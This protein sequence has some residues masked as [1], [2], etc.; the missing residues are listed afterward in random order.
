MRIDLL[1]KKS[2]L[3]LSLLFCINFLPNYANAQLNITDNRTA[4][5]LVEK[6][7][8]TGVITLNASLNC[9]T[10]ANGF[11]DGTSNLGLDSGIVLSSGAVKTNGFNTGVDGS[12]ALSPSTSYGSAG[13]AMLTTLINSNTG[14]SITTHDACVLQFDFVP[15]GDTVKFDYVF[16]SEE[17]PTY[18][19]SINDVF[20]FF[21]SGPGIIGTRNIATVPG[22]TN[23]MVGIS[24]INNG[25]GSAVGNPCMQNTF[26]NGPYTQYYVNN[27]NGTTVTYNG[28]TQVLQAIS[29][30]SPCDTYHLK[31]AIADASDNILDSGV[32]IKA[33]SL[34]S[35]GLTASATGMNTTISD[36]ATIVRGCPSAKVTVKRQSAAPT[37]LN[38]PYILGGTAVNG[39]DYALLSGTVTIL[40][41]E[42]EGIIEIQ[43]LPLPTPV[44]NKEVIVYIT[45]PYACGSGAPNIL[46]SAVIVIQDSIRLELSITNTV[47]CLGQSLTEAVTY[48]TMFGPLSY[49]WTP[50]LNVNAPTIDQAVITFDQAGQYEYAIS[51][52]IAGG[53]STCRLSTATVNI[54]VENILVNIGN[55]TTLCSA[56]VYPMFGETNPLDYNNSFVYA[57]GPVAN[58]QNATT[59]TPVFHSDVTQQ[60][61][62]QVTTPNGCVGRDTALITVNPSEFINLLPSDTGFCPANEIQVVANST[63]VNNSFI[64][65]ANTYIW[66]PAIGVSATDINNPILTPSV[67]TNYRMIATSKYGCEDTS[68]VN[69]EIY[70]DALVHLPKEVSIYAGESYQIEPQ[71]NAIYFN[72]YP[73]SGLNN[74]NIANPLAT[75][76]V[77]TRYFYTAK[78]ESGCEYKDSIDVLILD[79]ELVEIPNS[80]NANNDGIAPILKGGAKLVSFEVY[81]RWGAQV[82][83]TTNEQMKW[84]GQNKGIAVPM[85]VYVYQIKYVSKDNKAMNK[86]GNITLVR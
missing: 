7:V 1:H 37:V 4:V 67:S 41:N 84:T 21:I 83:Q 72:W 20:G 63:L 10:T 42:T 24:T 12:A 58:F 29:P 18:N 65:T 26:G 60:V 2:L 85:G 64:D 9:Q 15:S 49:Y 40:P 43:A 13:D 79:K 61:Y 46:D 3:G 25:T 54:T 32:F 57:W 27:T 36:T 50:P 14:G 28:F 38:V 66:T 48:D 45:S 59:K 34:T 81:D 71:T 47:L 62:L 78:T 52:A 30:V 5:Q 74:G 55:D 16:G 76:I 44:G 19:C 39:V 11:F 6:L 31:L 75:P 80:F 17:Y 68:Y 33:G 35:V 53:G 82:Y 77:N 70:P 86:T 73:V 56:Q 22:T 69:I 8:G 51:A 23:V